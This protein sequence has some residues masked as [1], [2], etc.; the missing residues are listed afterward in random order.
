MPVEYNWFIYDR[1]IEIISFPEWLTQKDN[2]NW[3]LITTCGL[4]DIS[5]RCIFRRK[6]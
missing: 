3:E 5:I 2:E 4:W 6:I 1:K